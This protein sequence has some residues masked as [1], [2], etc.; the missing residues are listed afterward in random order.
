MSPNNVRT[1]N[2]SSGRNRN[3][4]FY[5]LMQKLRSLSFLPFQM[6]VLLWLGAKG[7]RSIR[8]L[9]RIHRRGRRTKGGAD[10]LAKAPGSEVDVA[11]QVRH[12]RT[13]LQRRVVDELWGFMLRS[14]VPLGL[15]VTN[16][17]VMKGADRAASEFPGRPI[18]LVSCGQLCSSLSSLELGL[19]RV[20]DNWVVDEG[21]FRTADKLTLA[22]AMDVAAGL[23][24]RSRF[25]DGVRWTQLVSGEV[26]SPEGWPPVYGI[27]FWVAV[28][29]AILVALIWLESGGAR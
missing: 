24:R 10:F 18:Q 16:S 9:G 3:S 25:H 15:I 12:W 7:F 5:A 2:S 1:D 22:S 8:P 21:F 20:R 13:P 14:G 26:R 29:V 6:T 17:D 28:A 23:G 19:R 27:W 4:A 11:I